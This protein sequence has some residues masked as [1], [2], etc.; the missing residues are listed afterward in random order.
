MIN[1]NHLRHPKEKFY[2]TLMVLVSVWFSIPLLVAFC[3]PLIIVWWILDLYFRAVIYGNAVRV[4]A[5]QYPEIHKIILEQAEKLN[6]RYIPE[7]FVWN[8]HGLVNSFA[9]RFLSRKYILLL[10][11]I[12]DLMLSHGRLNELSMVIG[13]QIGYHAAGHTNIWK[14]LLIWPAYFIPFLGAAYS[15]A[16][17]LTADRI[18]YVLTDDIMACQR[19]LI[20][21]AHGS[22]NLSQKTDIDEFLLQEDRIPWLMGFIHKI[23]ST[24]PRITKRVI[25]ITKYHI[26]IQAYQYD[27]K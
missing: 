23:Y 7:V 24:H 3:I 8:G 21:L 18:G 17:V 22:K 4:T 5:R 6:L 11:S 27:D 12:V 2:L 1:V 16:C 20:A 19:A 14:D 26:R 10:S 9:I 25:E 15:R 13:N